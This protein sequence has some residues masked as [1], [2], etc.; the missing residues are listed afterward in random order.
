MSL[1][2]FLFPDAKTDTEAGKK[3]RNADDIADGNGVPPSTQTESGAPPRGDMPHPTENN[4]K[5]G[6]VAV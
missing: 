5:V 1:F 3:A 2:Q 4:F 6:V